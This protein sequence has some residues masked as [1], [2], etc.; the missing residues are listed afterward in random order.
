MIWAWQVCNLPINEAANQL[1]IGVTV[2][3]KYC[4]KF[5]IPRWPYRILSSLKKL[6]V[7]M[8]DTQQQSASLNVSFSPIRRSSRH[9]PDYSWCLSIYQP[10]TLLVFLCVVGIVAAK[11]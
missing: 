6:I 5:D 1:D 4:R 2:L 8:E 3:K 7:S 11:S 9:L 10:Q